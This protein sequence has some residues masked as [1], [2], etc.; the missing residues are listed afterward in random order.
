MLASPTISIHPENCELQRSGIVPTNTIE[1]KRY[2]K[3]FF[4]G[5]KVKANCISQG[6][7]RVQ[8]NAFP[9]RPMCLEI[10]CPWQS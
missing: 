10:K 3:W 5:R 2:N 4:R 6:E 1:A 8:R 9:R 7:T